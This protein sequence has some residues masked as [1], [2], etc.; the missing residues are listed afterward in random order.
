[1]KVITPSH[2]FSTSTATYL[3]PKLVELVEMLPA[4]RSFGT[5]IRTRRS[6]LFRLSR[7][8]LGTGRLFLQLK[9]GNKAVSEK[10]FIRQQ[11]ISLVVCA[12]KL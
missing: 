10:R 8:L 1:M 2:Q 7:L 6:S 12:T 5:V 9:Y 11:E 3:F 4:G